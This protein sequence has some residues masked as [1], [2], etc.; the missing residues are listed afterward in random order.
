LP[1]SAAEPTSEIVR[2]ASAQGFAHSFEAVWKAS[3]SRPSSRWN[4]YATRSR[5]SIDPGVPDAELLLRQAF[6]KDVP[7]VFTVVQRLD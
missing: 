1:E 3:I 6:A 7:Q 5:K 2:D 4:R